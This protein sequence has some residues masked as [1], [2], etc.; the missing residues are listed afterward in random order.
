MR[1]LFSRLTGF[2]AFVLFAL[3]AC[4]TAPP[5]GPVIVQ[6]APQPTVPVP[7]E[8]EPQ[9]PDPEDFVTTEVL[10]GKQPVRVAL[11]LPFT[12]GSDNVKKISQAMSNAAQLAAFESGNERY[13]LIPKD[14]EGTP[15]GAARAAREALDEG[16]EVILGPLFS[17]SVEAAASV[18]RLANVPMIA[19]SSDMSIAG[20]GVYLLSFPPEVEVARITD[21]AI[22]NGYVRFGVISP[23][24]EYGS[25]VSSSFA[26]ETFVR[27]GVVVHQETYQPAIDTMQGPAKNLA[28]YA[29]GC[30]TA[31]SATNDIPFNGDMMPTASQAGLGFQA[32]L[33]PES[34]QLLRAL[35][36]ML[37][38]YDVN[39]RCVKILGISAWNN[40]RLVREP[41]LSGSWFAAPDPALSEGFKERYRKVYGEVPPR[42]ASLAYDAALLT[43]RLSKNPPMDRFT[44]ENLTDP[45][46][47]LGADGLFRL[48]PDGR[49]ERGLAILEIRPSGIKVIES[50]PRSFVTLGMLGG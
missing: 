31:P 21:Y 27:G 34:G 30:S 36:P 33:M 5:S 17:E 35:A 9:R 19:F 1:P 15:E 50:A 13:L 46:G 39:V 47:Y 32:V 38:Y 42:L 45:N 28:R 23:Q 26:E 10:D 18:T 24:T 22:K 3:A 7:V 41:A 6:P 43:A 25:R 48:L 8:P 49:V 14:T 12:S 11:L 4:E 16:A 2:A 40:P 20:N 29:G 44:H 37:P